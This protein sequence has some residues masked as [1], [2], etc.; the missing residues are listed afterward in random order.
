TGTLFGVS[1]F[2]VRFSSKD[3]HTPGDAP[4][5]L[6]AMNPAALKTNIS[7]LKEGGM[8]IVNSGNFG[9]KDL[10]KA[11]YEE[12]PLED[13]TLHDRYNF[14]EL[15]L[16]DAVIRATEDSGVS[17]KDALRCKNLLALGILYWVYSRPLDITEKWLEEKFGKKPE[18]LAANLAALRAGHAIAENTELFQSRFIVEAAPMETG[19]YRNIMGNSATAAGLVA[20]SQLSGLPLFFGSYPITPASDVLHA[21]ARYKNHGVITF[22][23][24]DE[25]AGICSALGASFA[26]ALGVTSTSGPGLALKGEAL[27]LAVMVELPLVVL[28]VQ[29]GG[30]STGLPTKTEQADLLQAIFGRHGEC[31]LPVISAQS[32]SDCL[33]AA[34]DA[35]RIATQFMTP[36]I[37]LSDGYIANGAEP[38]RIPSV[39]EFEPFPVEHVTESEGF[40]P[41]ARDPE[42]LARNWA[43]PGF[44]GL[45][46]R[47]GGLEKEDVTGDVN[48]E[49]ENHEKMVSLR[50]EKVQRVAQTY[51]PLEVTGPQ[52]GGILALGWGST[53]GAI[54][55]ACER[56]RK[57]GKEIA[58]VHLRHVWPLPND[59]GDIL[60]RYDKVVVPELNRGQMARLL[61]SEYLVDVESMSKVQGR[62]FTS[63]EIADKLREM[64]G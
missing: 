5:V 54:R 23:A 29:R 14:I 24:E 35:C 12:N 28:N 9:T 56:L 52:E 58:Q 47:I 6:V 64:I 15:D 10:E 32:P 41:Y 11:H 45:E 34:I 61:R 16:N 1:G 30:P 44:K 25:I 63:S 37:L 43:V 53:Y 7:D 57:E 55:G 13:S 31:P 42:T 19:T 22:Q 46:H 27:G 33:Y 2:Q 59:L 36:V 3:I 40:Q 20:G 62:P 4:D 8:L 26:G 50:E 49:P 38:F 18:V 48:Y 51:A 60:R 39:D 21:L 17:R